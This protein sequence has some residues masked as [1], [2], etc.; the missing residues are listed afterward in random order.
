MGKA[1]VKAALQ[2]EIG[3]GRRM[4][5]VQQDQHF[6]VGVGVQADS[7]RVVVAVAIAKHREVAASALIR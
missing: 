4:D 5:A 7:M 6:G 3:C 2:T 1:G